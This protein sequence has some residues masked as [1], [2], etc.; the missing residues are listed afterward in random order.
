M[1]QAA[2]RSQA[3]FGPGHSP[4]YLPQG[5]KH[6]AHPR[7]QPSEAMPVRSLTLGHMPMAM[8]R[9]LRAAS[10]RSCRTSNWAA[11]IQICR[12]GAVQI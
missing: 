9:I 7:H 10:S 2:A 4:L 5:T 11:M 6:P 12:A 3:G 1:P 8:P